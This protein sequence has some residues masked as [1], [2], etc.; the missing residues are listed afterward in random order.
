VADSDSVE[1]R[2]DTEVHVPSG[3]T[4]RRVLDAIRRQ[5][6]QHDLPAG[7]EEELRRLLNLV[8]SGRGGSRLPQALL[9]RV[10]EVCRRYNVPILVDD[11]RA[12]VACPA[13][14]SRRDLTPQEEV[15]LR[16]L[17]L[18]DSSVLV[19][20]AEEARKTV[21]VTL[22]ARRQ[23]RTL[24][25]AEDRPG[26]QRWLDRCVSDLGLGSPHVAALSDAGPDTWVAVG[27]YDDLGALPAETLRQEY[28]MVVCD[29]LCRVD[30]VTL[31]RI[32]RGVGA[33]YLLGLAAEPVRADGLHQTLFLALGGVAHRISSRKPRAPVRL[34]LRPRLTDF[35]FPGY[36]GRRQYQAMVAALAADRPRAEAVA[37]DVAREAAEGSPCLVLSERRDHLELL[38]GLLPDGI[39]QKT[40]TIN[41]TVRL[42]ERQQIISRFERG[43]LTV[44]LATS[45]IA[46][47]SLCTPRVQRVFLAFP[48][49]YARKLEKVV[50]ALM[51]PAPGQQSA[52]LYD[53]DD[54]AVE[55][56]HRAFKKRA[57]F[58]ARIRREAEQS[59][60]LELF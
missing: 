15:A 14:R 60:Q 24:V 57:E 48:F 9:P 19:A 10:T 29:G 1:I 26:I 35:R 43:E 55:P 46:L 30:A 47:E 11:R 6:R 21:A 31:M 5:L 12:M 41:S 22:V 28:G 54:P 59:A 58:L 27:G 17:L 25:A 33:R 52:V 7:E 18:R 38:A 32:I 51:A 42:P 49:S 45:Q 40:M 20:A 37:L 2:V 16:Q 4:P 23:Q 39:Q 3:T 44:I 53:Y 13:L 34:T 8:Q 36:E 56:L 50:R